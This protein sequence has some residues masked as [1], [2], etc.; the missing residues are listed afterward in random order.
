MQEA[1]LLPSPA[2][3]ATL[4][5]HFPQLCQANSLALPQ[6]WCSGQHSTSVTS[7][8]IQKGLEKQR[9][10]K[11]APVLPKTG[12]DRLF[13]STLGNRELTVHNMLARPTPLEAHDKSF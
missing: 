8:S 13:F 10:L 7:D 5:R 9:G 6:P 3:P 1:E 11:Q 2:P 4:G 12:T